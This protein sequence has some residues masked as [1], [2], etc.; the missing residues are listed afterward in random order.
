MYMSIKHVAFSGVFM[1]SF[2]IKFILELNCHCNV[3]LNECAFEVAV[4]TCNIISNVNVILERLKLFV[5][6]KVYTDFDTV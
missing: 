3:K 5:V 4:F 2:K 1:T 6:G